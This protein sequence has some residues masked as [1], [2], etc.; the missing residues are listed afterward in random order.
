MNIAEAIEKIRQV[1]VR[2]FSVVDTWFDAPEALRAHLPADGGWNIPQILEHISLTNHFLL[3]LIDKA[4]VKALK[5]VNLTQFQSELTHYHFESDRLEQIGIHRS[6]A[7][8]R[9]AHMEPEGKRTPEE[10]RVLLKEQ[11]QRCLDTLIQLPN[12]EGIL[13][14]TTMTVNELGKL[15]V[16]QYLYFLAQHARRHIA[17]LNRVKEEFEATRGRVIN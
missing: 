3:I 13:S 10:I 8:V 2:T 16:Y 12:G 17:Q 9:P 1:L 15:D 14:T 6:F 11:L 4:R 7:W 5:N